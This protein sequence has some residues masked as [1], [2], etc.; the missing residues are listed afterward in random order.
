MTE[1]V[2]ALAGVLL[3]AV[4]GVAGTAGLERWR[5][6]YLRRDARIDRQAATLR[7]ALDAYTAFVL[8]WSQPANKIALGGTVDVLDP[9]IVAGPPGQTHQKLTAVT[10]RIHV[11]SIR[12]RMGDFIDRVV[13]PVA[14]GKITAARIDANAA[15][16]TQVAADIGTELRKLEAQ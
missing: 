12:L 15:F 8:A 10:E 7:E 6:S 2:F 9:T 16:G 5:H 13:T 11:E 14:D 1:G 3:G 4:L